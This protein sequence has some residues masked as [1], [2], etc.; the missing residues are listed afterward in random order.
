M[1]E[2]VGQRDGSGTPADDEAA[3]EVAMLL[4]RVPIGWSETTYAGR[5]WG[6]TRAQSAG[7]RTTS[8]YAEELGGTDVVS[9]N[10]YLVGGAWV[11]KPCEM[12]EEKVRAFLKEQQPV[13]S[14]RANRTSMSANTAQS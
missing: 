5:R 1:D 10:A 12:P 8:V 14:Q 9:T 3:D 2:P 7:G 6:V 4:D 11:L 13:T